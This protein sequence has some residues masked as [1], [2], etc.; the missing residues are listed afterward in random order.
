MAIS[1]SWNFI[2]ICIINC[3]NTNM[4]YIC[5]DLINSG[6]TTAINELKEKIKS[7]ERYNKYWQVIL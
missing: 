6:K 1:T 3:K 2:H 5:R 7:D 4:Q